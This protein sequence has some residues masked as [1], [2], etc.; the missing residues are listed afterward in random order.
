MQCTC[1]ARYHQHSNDVPT[2]VA[3]QLFG[4]K[5]MKDG[6]NIVSAY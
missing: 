6:G 5:A 4:A 1:L 3:V 2:C